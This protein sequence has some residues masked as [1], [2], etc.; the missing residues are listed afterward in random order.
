MQKEY[1]KSVIT[2]EKIVL[3]GHYKKLLSI[4]FAVLAGLSLIA[5]LLAGSIS[6]TV[7][8][9]QYYKD[10][11]TKSNTYEDLLE[12]GVPSV[13]MQAT[14]SDD[15]MMNMLA[16]QGIVY[17]IKNSIPASWIQD[18]TELLIDDISQFIKNS[19]KNPEIVLQ[20]HDI[21]SYLVQI[22][23]GLTVLEQIIPSCADAKNTSDELKGLINVDIDCANMAVSLDDIKGQISK[24]KIAISQLEVAE[25]NLTDE[26][27]KGADFFTGV[28]QFANRVSGMYWWSLVIFILS[29]VVILLLQYKDI[30]KLI[31]YIAIPIAGSSGMVLLAAL[32]SKPSVLRSIDDNFHLETTQE[33]HDIIIRFLHTAVIDRY[34]SVIT[35]SSILLVISLAIFIVSILLHRKKHE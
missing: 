12:K 8:N 11:F 14:I 20:L 9:P 21:D 4:I 25:V 22:G 28:N 2:D 27:Q 7:V 29:L 30:Y 24:A 26:V 33:M 17:V 16:R 13:V 15:A 35:I 1:H 19:K 34:T 18:K 6:N 23:D 31:K 32:I 5:F 10:I 3:Y